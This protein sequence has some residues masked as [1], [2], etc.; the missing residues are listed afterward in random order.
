MCVSG[1]L[2]QKKCHCVISSEKRKIKPS[3]PL[4]LCV[5]VCKVISWFFLHAS[6]RTVWHATRR[7]YLWHNF[8]RMCDSQMDKCHVSESIKANVYYIYAP[9][10]GNAWRGH[11]KIAHFI[12]DHFSG[13]CHTKWLCNRYVH[14]IFAHVFQSNF[15]W[16]FSDGS[17]PYRAQWVNINPKS[18]RIES[19]LARSAL[20]THSAIIVIRDFLI[21]TLYELQRSS[22]FQL[23]PY[24]HQVASHYTTSTMM[25]TMMTIWV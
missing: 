9:N 16:E 11:C 10:C 3:V 17:P 21:K 2:V 13:P 25:M 4:F 14:S 8:R 1:V 24:F 18:N 12:F 6:R 15:K 19:N 20:S 7:V 5:I 22:W 23:I